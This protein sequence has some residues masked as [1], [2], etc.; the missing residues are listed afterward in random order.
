MNEREREQERER[1]RRERT[2]KSKIITLSPSSSPSPRGD[3]PTARLFV[4]FFSRG[5]RKRF[6]AP[7]EKFENFSHIRVCAFAGLRAHTYT[8][9]HAGE[10][11]R[12]KERE[13]EYEREYERESER[14]LQREKRFLLNAIYYT[15]ILYIILLFFIYRTSYAHQKPETRVD[16]NPKHPMSQ[17][18]LSFFLPEKHLKGETHLFSLSDTY[19]LKHRLSRSLSLAL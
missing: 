9:T 4:F 15:I 2:C 14:L 19:A 11:K 5:R 8:Y 1:E 6:Y 16:K 7:G 12:E 18:F 13:R 3:P 10:T 17:F